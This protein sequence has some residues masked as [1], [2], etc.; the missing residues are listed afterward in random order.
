VHTGLSQIGL[1]KL[2]D[3]NQIV[4][5]QHWSKVEAFTGWDKTN[6]YNIWNGQT[7]D[8]IFYAAENNIDCCVRNYCGHL[9]EFTMPEFKIYLTAVP[10]LGPLKISIFWLKILT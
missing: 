3:V 5:K 1:E 8:Q 4:V 2:N 10:F 9:R 6:R 7:G